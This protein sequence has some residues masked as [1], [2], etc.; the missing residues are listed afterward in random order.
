MKQELI[1]KL[2]TILANMP[3]RAEHLSLEEWQRKPK[4]DKWS[5]KEILGHLIDSA[6][7]NLKRFTEIQYQL[8]TYQ[9]VGYEQDHLVRVNKYQEQQI[10][11]LVSLW[12]ALNQQIANV[13]KNTDEQLL[14][15]PI[16]LPDLKTKEDLAWLMTDYIDHL[17]HHLNQIFDH[18]HDW[19]RDWPYRITVGH[20][21]QEL[22]KADPA[23]F[24]KVL[25]HGSMEVEIYVPEG[26]DLQQ[27]H[28]RDE[29]YVVISGHGTFVNGDV[30]HSFQPGDVLFVPAG[31][32]HRFEDFSEDFRTW[33]VFYG[34]EGG[35]GN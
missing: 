12:A 33:V 25:E 35:E 31:V 22:Q 4:P 27:P 2:Q 29:L 24:V 5:K 10:T 9:V 15:T 23:K 30:S 20:A 14:N 32:S 26:K 17:N 11:Q 1:N 28:S 13:W 16:L 6:L 21:L 8:G 7:N 19:A 18:I 34:P 3:L